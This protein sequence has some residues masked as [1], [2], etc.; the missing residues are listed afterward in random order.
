MLLHKQILSLLRSMRFLS[1]TFLSKASLLLRSIG[2]LSRAFLLCIALLS[3]SLYGCANNKVTL[4]PLP[5]VS[6]EIKI[7][8]DWRANLGRGAR[9]QLR[10]QTPS[11][12]TDNVIMCDWR[13]VTSLNIENG[14][15]IWRKKLNA[16]ITGCSGGFGDR[17]YVVD[18]DG[19]VYA[20]DSESGEIAWQAE[21]NI[22]STSAPTANENIVLVQTV[23]E[24]LFALDA[25]DGSQLWS[26]SAFT[27]PLTLFGS[28]RPLL[29]GN[30]VLS[31]F[32]DGS[33]VVLDQRNG[34]VI[35]F[36]QLVLPQGT[37]DL[38]NLVDIDGGAVINNNIM[39]VSSYGGAVIALNLQTGREVWRR[40]LAS[41]LPMVI[42]NEQ[43]ILLDNDSRL[44]ALNLEDGETLW[45]NEDFLYRGLTGPALIDEYLILGDDK[46]H[47]HAIN[48]LNGEPVARRKMSITGF[49]NFLLPTSQG[50][51]MVEREGFAS[52]VNIR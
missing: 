4:K 49:N 21:L 37:S 22:G 27:P 8:L 38:E 43:L 30:V 41:S 45:E 5:K 33:V 7:T 18:E 40:N 19:V 47:V 2:F 52:M 48:A 32:A 3:L 24:K 11:E 29:L 23:N 15:R 35:S 51:L 16:P 26:Y 36:S 31:G 25:N 46:G 9:L 34:N 1:K 12:G 10:H 17:I 50:I 44:Y 28:F 39:Y 6:Q 14:N 13:R 42:Y 20:L